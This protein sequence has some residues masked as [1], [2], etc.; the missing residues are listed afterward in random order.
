M[1]AVLPRERGASFE[2]SRGRSGD[3]ARR[4]ASDTTRGRSG[5]RGDADV[6]TR[7][8]GSGCSARACCIGGGGV[9]RIAASHGTSGATSMTITNTRCAMS[10]R[11][12][13]SRREMAL[14]TPSTSS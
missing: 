2:A 7:M 1:S 6:S 3:A 8:N 13:A 9:S 11:R 5:G 4:S 12:I 14:P 10:D